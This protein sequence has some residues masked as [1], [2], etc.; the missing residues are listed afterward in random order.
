L[1]READI[2]PTDWD[3]KHARTDPLPQYT[4]GQQLFR[5]L[6]GSG[7]NFFRN[8]V[9]LAAII[10]FFIEQTYPSIHLNTNFVRVLRLVRVFGMLNRQKEIKVMLGLLVKTVQ[11]SSYALGVLFLLSLVFVVFFGSIMY[12]LESGHYVVDEDFP[13]GQWIRE[14]Y[15]P[16]NG[17]V[18]HTA[19]PFNSIGTTM[20][21]VITTI[22]T[23]MFVY[24][25]LVTDN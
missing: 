20:Y 13:N 9:D 12:A 23:G 6:C 4:L 18:I 11:K 19:S 1:C 15:N 22:T 25:K 5:F 3:D 24:I 14:S 17:L 8:A 7:T 16:S 2:L 21:Y 10:P